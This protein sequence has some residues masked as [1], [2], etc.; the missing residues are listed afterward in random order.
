MTEVIIVGAG[1]AGLTAA[2]VLGR[3]GRET[4]VI[5]GGRPRNAPAPELHMFPSRDGF[6]PA[7]LLRLA[8]AELAAYPAV[9]RTEGTVT[10]VEGKID[11]FTVTLADGSR[12]R[13][14]RLILA[15]GVVDTMPRTEGVAERFGR[16]VHHCP[17]CHGNEVRGRTVGVLGNGAQGGMLSLYL[18]DR[19][20]ED[21]VLCT[22][23]PADL[24]APVAALLDARGIAVREEPVLRVD[25]EPD[26]LT[27]YLS[28]GEPLPRQALFHRTGESPNTALAA[29][30]GCEILPDG[31]LR[32]DARQ[33]TTVPGVYASGDL[34]RQAELP[35][36]LTFVATAAASG[37][38][39]AV[40]IDGE[41]FRAS[42]PTV[43]PPGN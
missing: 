11:D 16:G 36:A 35:V 39:A 37:Q 13:A 1:T 28:G 31:W 33:G 4:L 42:F 23:G 14:R 41:L 26:A 20:T 21:V 27:V 7:E 22:D 5:D 30:L 8:R 25:G 32:V 29:Q 38:V 2:Q 9:R 43:F 17:F 40:H 6:P 3:Q 12:E 34:A 19:F 18:R 24:P 15:T 10:A